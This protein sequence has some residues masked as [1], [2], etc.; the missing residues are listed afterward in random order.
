VKNR[1]DLHL[2]NPHAKIAIRVGGADLVPGLVVVVSD[3]GLVFAFPKRLFALIAHVGF[4]VGFLVL[5]GHLHRDVLREFP[6][7]LWPKLVQL[8]DKLVGVIVDGALECEAVEAIHLGLPTGS[9][10]HVTCLELRSL[11]PLGVTS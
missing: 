6:E 1:R 2:A 9:N 11:F 4:S 3:L 7:E 8:A 5:L 10:R